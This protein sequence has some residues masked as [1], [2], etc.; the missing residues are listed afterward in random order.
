MAVTWV[1]DVLGPGFEAT[2]LAFADDAEGPVVATVVRHRSLQPA[3]A[4]VLYIHGFN[5]YFFQAEVARWFAGRGWDFYAVDL[6][7]YGRSLRPGQTANM[8]TDLGAY[9]EDLDAAAEVVTGDGHHRIVLM[10]HSTGGLSGP[11]WWA[12]RPQLPVVGMVLNSPFLAFKQPPA[13]RAALLPAAAAV[14]RWNP[15]RPLP[16]GLP[17]LYGESI[18]ASRRGEWDFDLVWK[19]LE[20]PVRVGWVGAVARG[21]HTV[22][23]GL[24]LA[25]PTLVLGSTRTVTTRRWV[26]DMARGDA[27]LDADANARSAPAI[28]RHVTIV[29]VSD[30]LHDVYLSAA[31][32]RAE[33]LSTTGRGGDAGGG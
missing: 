11:L 25:V 30:A 15:N 18:H 31:P 3:T 27:V 32:V 29:R 21:Q 33:A 23:S 13:V 22:R 26:D 19:P 17:R 4:A 7:R 9:D 14:A 6:R 28:G 20:A 10:G 1:P 2:T 24:D 12:R 16:A 8:C 5:D